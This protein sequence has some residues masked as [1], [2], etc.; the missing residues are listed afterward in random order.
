MVIPEFSDLFLMTY[1]KIY[2]SFVL[3]YGIMKYNISQQKLTAEKKKLDLSIL[4]DSRNSKH[5]FEV[6]IFIFNSS[7]ISD[8]DNCADHPYLKL[9]FPYSPSPWHYFIPSYLHLCT[10]ACMYLETI[11]SGLYKKTCRKL[12]HKSMFDLL[13]SFFSAADALSLSHR[14][15]NQI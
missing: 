10:A 5:S 9:S 1:S 2:Y 14:S 13:S 15:H 12:L 11:Q 3:T 4:H 7:L 6:E 8:K